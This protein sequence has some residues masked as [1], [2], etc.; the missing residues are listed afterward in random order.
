MITEKMLE[1]AAAELNHAILSSLDNSESN[2]H[3]FSAKFERKMRHVIRKSK[4][5]ATYQ[6]LKRA[7]CYAIALLLGFASLL[8][9]SPTVR[10]AVFGWVKE[11]FS[12][13]TSYYFAGVAIET[14]K[15]DY[16]LCDL[17]EDYTEL[18]RNDSGGCT[19]II[20]KN[21]CGQ[22]LHFSYSNTPNDTY[23]YVYHEGYSTEE[24]NQGI[25][26][27][28]FISEDPDKA[29]GISWKSEDGLT[30]FHLS[31][32]LSSEQLIVLAQSVKKII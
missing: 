24:I 31:A 11:Q 23:L 26:Y 29:N 9:I 6:T 21:Q 18:A 2:T 3:Q 30:I 17:P 15:P 12:T 7:S 10:A 4:H 8:A 5:P 1:E 28:I 14:S 25:Q 19:S 22:M 20:Y 13:F 27:D 16:I 32:Y